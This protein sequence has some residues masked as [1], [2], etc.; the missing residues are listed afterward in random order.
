MNKNLQL[1]DEMSSGEN[2]NVMFFKQLQVH[3]HILLHLFNPSN[4]E[5]TSYIVP[6]KLGHVRMHMKE[7]FRAN[8]LPLPTFAEF[9][10]LISILEFSQKNGNR[11]VV[12]NS[13]NDLINAMGYSSCQKNMDLLNRTI[14]SYR[15]LEIEYERSILLDCVPADHNKIKYEKLA[16]NRRVPKSNYCSVDLQIL[17]GLCNEEK[18]KNTRVVVFNSDFWEICNDKY[19]WTKVVNLSIVKQFKSPRQ[20]Q[21]YLFLCKWMNH[22]QLTIGNPLTIKEFITETGLYFNE[23]DPKR[24][25]KLA[26]E[27]KTT[28]D[29][30]YQLDL[31]CRNQDPKFANKNQQWNVKLRESS[32]NKKLS[33][34]R[35]IQFVSPNM[36][37][38]P[39]MRK[40]E[41]LELFPTL[42]NKEWE[43]ATYLHLPQRKSLPPAFVEKVKQQIYNYHPDPYADL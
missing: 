42:T 3:Q 2:K 33:D 7:D 26:T 20:L 5:R 18:N 6:T 38:N 34:E 35:R 14:Q 9:K 15:R 40:D 43:V 31:E 23:S 27:I 1:V 19:S 4:E 13:A 11:S 25:T 29:L 16:I 17:T 41:W 39:D 21:I 8:K 12:F 24:Y 30:I 28:L 10:L 32:F 22:K 36:Y 37:Y